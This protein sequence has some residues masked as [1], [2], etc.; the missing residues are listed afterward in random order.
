M[1]N[2]QISDEVKHLRDDNSSKNTIIKLLTENISDITKSFSNK[3]NQEKPF[4]SPK[5]MLIINL[6]MAMGNLPIAA[7]YLPLVPT[8]NDIW[9]RRLRTLALEIFKTL[10][11]LNPA[12]MKNL[13]AR[14]AVSKDKEKEKKIETPNQNTVKFGDKHI[15]SLGPHIWNGLPGEI[16][17]ET[18]CNKFKE[19]S[20]VG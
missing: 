4:I 15:R 16:K 10:N 18:S 19:Y 3:Q 7:N 14:R 13:S 20:Q 2:G 17:N 8:G 11:D 6:P 12:F 1:N 9:V 5:N